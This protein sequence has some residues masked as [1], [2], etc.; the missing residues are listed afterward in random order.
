MFKL[1]LDVSFVNNSVCMASTSYSNNCGKSELWH[2]RL[3]HVHYKRL[4]DMSKMSLIPGFELNG[5][6]CK[7]CMLTK[8]TRYLSP[9]MSL[10]ILRY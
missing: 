4:I 3:G 1:N 8:I 2:A 6:K 9:K 5:E 10:E 7:T